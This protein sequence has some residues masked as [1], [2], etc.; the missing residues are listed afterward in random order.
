MKRFLIIPR[1]DLIEESRRL[2]EKYNL[3]FE[4]NDFFSPDI[5]DDSGRTDDIINFYTEGGLPRYC[6]LHGAFLDVAVFSPDRKIREISA[7]RIE[8][9][10]AAAKKIGAKAVIFHTNYNPFLNSKQYVDGWLEANAVYWGGVLEKHR[11]ISIYLENMFDSSPDVM[12]RL[13]ERLC[14]NENFGL[15]F[16]YA[17]AS[18]TRI[19]VKEW[20]EK[21]S[22][23]IRHIHI[24]DNDFASDLHLAVGSGKINW[25]EFYSLYGKYMNDASVLIE[26]SSPE[27]QEKS[28]HRL[29]SDGFMKA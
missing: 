14:R 29:I 23:Y 17:H 20:A 12:A 26:T 8:Q 18:L 16:D 7:L 2:A 19:P 15:C 13:A 11:D 27:N 1:C 3:G 9:S 5:L 25:N 22:K 4:F 24:N 21:L 10:L 28:I 6:T